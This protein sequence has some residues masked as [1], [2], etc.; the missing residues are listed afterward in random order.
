MQVLVV[1]TPF[2]PRYSRASRSPAVTKSAT[3]YYPYWLAY[4]VGVLE[5]DGFA[6][7]FLDASAMRLDHEEVYRRASEGMPQV[8]LIDT[9]TASVYNDVAVALRIK[10]LTGAR[11]LLV[12]THASATARETIELDE[13]IDAVAVAEYDYTARDF[14]RA[15]RDTTPLRDVAGIVYREDGMVCVTPRR[16]YIREL[17]ELPFVS[18]V[19]KKHFTPAVMRRFFYGECLHPVMTILSGRG[20][21][22]QCSFC[23]YPQVMTGHAYRYR[24][25]T[26]V[27]DELAYISREFPWVKEVFIEDDTLTVHKK[28]VMAL[29]EEILRRGLRVIWSANS[30][31]DVDRET[32]IAI[33][34]AGCRLLCVG[35]ESGDQRVLDNMQKKLRVESTY[36][37]V[38]DARA[39]G[40]KV[41][42]CFL[43]GNPG[44]NRESLNKTLEMALRLSPDTAQF[45]PIMI[46]PGTKAYDWAARKGY[47]TVQG[48]DA[49]L[50][51]EGLHNSVVSTPE[52]T[53]QELTD[54]C[55]AA[56]RAF[57]LRPRYLGAKLLQ[58]LRSPAELKRLARGGLT[59]S[60]FLLRGT[61]GGRQR[62]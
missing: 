15:V 13:R 54:W 16:P 14:A 23:V 29:A 19:Y 41:H 34:Q 6:V 58:G 56:R 24:S 57:Y 35:F 38:E 28:R 7:T 12:G 17:D 62:Q 31:A 30:R 2:L 32:L 37:F 60:R 21:P 26:D 11:V 48:Y 20:C 61:F 46:Y 1:N 8:A 45:Y 25:V 52:L 40:V 36:R 5:Q 44:E 49:W 59:L 43:V 39:A 47:I 42:G 9:T 51:P 53:W 50:T 22:H 4:A 18:S 55:Y 10:E 3:L 33:G 27:V